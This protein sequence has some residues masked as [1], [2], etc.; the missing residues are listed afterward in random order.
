MFVSLCAVVGR[1]LAR[2]A[3]CT[4]SC[5][6]AL[7]YL[8]SHDTL[9]FSCPLKQLFQLKVVFWSATWALN[10]ARMGQSVS[11][12]IMFV[13]ERLTARMVQMKRTVNPNAVKVWGFMS[14]IWLLKA[15]R[16]AHYCTSVSYN[17][18]F[19]HPVDNSEGR[20][21]PQTIQCKLKQIILTSWIYYIFVLV[22]LIIQ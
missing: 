18:F 16:K 14:S 22:W 2:W 8:C 10:C 11:P 21:V 20:M 9:T 5:S 12:T 15:A 19:V 1:M 7:I 6:H 4:I 13:M 17:T 3:S